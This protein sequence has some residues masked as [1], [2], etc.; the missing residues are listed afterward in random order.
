M[1][2]STGRKQLS[3][4]GNPVFIGLEGG[5]INFYNENQAYLACMPSR[6]FKRLFGFLPPKGNPICVKF[7]G[8]PIIRSS[9]LS[10]RLVWGD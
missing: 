8:R 5:Y 9:G 3:Q 2:G 6:D 10:N 7:T 1:G 4:D